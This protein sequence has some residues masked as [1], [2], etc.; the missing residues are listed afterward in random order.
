MVV[1]G[2]LILGCLLG[3]ACGGSLLRLGSFRLKYEKTVLVLFVIQAVARGR[4]GGAAMPG[5]TWIWA[6]ASMGLVVVLAFDYGKP[7]MTVAAFGVLLNLDA[8]LVNSGM[9]VESLGRGTTAAVAASGGQYVLT[10]AH[11][12]GSWLG[13][14]LLLTIGQTSLL[15]SVGDVLLLASVASVLVFGMTQI[16]PSGS[17]AFPNEH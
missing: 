3:W 8:T 12:V 9:P 6:I 1:F 11:T 2:A 13:D 4:I 7:G 17:T 10:G 14:V 16:E 15:L 5:A